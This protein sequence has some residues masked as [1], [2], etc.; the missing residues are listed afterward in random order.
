MRLPIPGLFH[1]NEIKSTNPS[2][3]STNSL[4][5][6]S[7]EC[8]RQLVGW[9]VLMNLCYTPLD[10]FAVYVTLYLLLIL[11]VAVISKVLED[12]VLTFFPAGLTVY[13]STVTEYFRSML[14]INMIIGVAVG[15]KLMMLWYD[16]QLKSKEL[17]SRQTQTE[18]TQLHA[19][20]K[21]TKNRVRIADAFLPI[22]DTF[23]DDFFR[24]IG[25][26]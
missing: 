5:M 6:D 14:T 1:G 8:F 26:G 3:K 7:A 12:H 2:C 10:M 21:V 16:A 24:R 17:I 23:K 11:F 19:Q 20:L 9:Q 22:G 25:E 18:L 13:N 4:I 15:L